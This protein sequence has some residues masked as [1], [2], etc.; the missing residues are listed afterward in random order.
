MKTNVEYRFLNNEIAECRLL[1]EDNKKYLEGHAAVFN[2]RS[3]LLFENNRFFYEILSPNAFDN[4]LQDENLD[5]PMTFNHERGRL[6]GRTK[7]NSLNIS[8]DEKG[9]KF[10]VEIPNTTTG[11]DVYELVKRGDLYENSFAFMV[12]KDNWSIDE[13][14]SNIRTINSIKKLAD[15]SVVTNG[16]YANTDVAARSYEEAIQNSQE[17]IYQHLLL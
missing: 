6:L 12:D 4:V 3:K 14:G 9:L 13:N 10:R 5:V 11:N 17:K 7:S 8:K 15:I 16:A 1:E 2:E